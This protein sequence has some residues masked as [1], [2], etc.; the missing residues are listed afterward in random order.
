MPRV[1]GCGDPIS[2]AADGN[3]D[4]QVLIICTPRFGAT[5]TEQ[6]LR[7]T[8]FLWRV[9]GIASVV[10]LTTLRVNRLRTLGSRC[11]AFLPEIQWPALAGCG[12]GLVPQEVAG[13]ADVFPGEGG[14]VG[15]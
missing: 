12:S 3:D 4:R 9:E 15:E 5:L 2:A 10:R 8:W 11:D 13:K 14:G 6:I 7:A 1:P